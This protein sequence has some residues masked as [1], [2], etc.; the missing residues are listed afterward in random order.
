M[1]PA[2]RAL[3][4]ENTHVL[5]RQLEVALFQTGKELFA[6]FAVEDVI[7][8][9]IDVDDQHS[10]IVLTSSKTFDS[11]YLDRSFELVVVE[12]HKPLVRN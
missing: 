8:F 11:G 1:R 12:I 5:I 3:H 2:E 6:P 4:L 7:V 10:R 9:I